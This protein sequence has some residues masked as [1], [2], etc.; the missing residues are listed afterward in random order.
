MTSCTV[1]NE[2]AIG[3]V[4]PPLTQLQPGDADGLSYTIIVDNALGPDLTNE[5]LQINVEPNPQGFNL[6]DSGYNTGSSAP[7]RIMVI[8]NKYDKHMKTVTII[9]RAKTFCL[10]V[11]MSTM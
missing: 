3:C 11:R 2:T 9:C 6:V 10:L 8:F 5:N 4:V 1:I 7:I